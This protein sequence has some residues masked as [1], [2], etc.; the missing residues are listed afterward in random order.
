[1]AAKKPAEPAQGVK[2]I[3]CGTG[4]RY[5]IDGIKV[6][7]VTTLIGAG[8]PK[9]ALVNWAARK[10]AEFV[11]DNLD[12]VDEWR[13]MSRDELVRTL[14]VIPEQVRN[15]AGKRGTDVHDYAE[16]LVKG[17]EVEYEEHLA[18]HVEAYIKFLDEWQVRPVLVERW[19]GSRSFRYGG[20]T[21]L[22]ADVITPWAIT[23]EH[24]PW[25]AETIPA[26][27][28]LRVI[29]DPKTSRSGLWPEVAYQLA[30]YWH[31]DFYM[32]GDTEIPMASL[33]IQHAAAVHVRADGY[34]VHFVDA[35]PETF[36]T[37]QHIATVA[38]RAKDGRELLIGK[39]VTS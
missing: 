23:P 6:D 28:P 11:A 7:G 34:D 32:D 25:L 36:K 3:K 20:T 18:G 31:A 30:A 35:G 8:L 39:A 5:T 15:T 12:K 14:K 10:V 24:C 26:G 9:P 16:H 17:E 4:H 22:V 13:A 19:V 33:G 1:M 21:D 2:K 29:F 27:T 38:R 37:F